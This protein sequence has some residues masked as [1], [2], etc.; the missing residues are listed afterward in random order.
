MNNV[1]S[2]FG[3]SYIDH[4]WRHGLAQSA[5]C[6]LEGNNVEHHPCVERPN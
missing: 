6:A 5:P 3:I 1:S 4:S 2:I